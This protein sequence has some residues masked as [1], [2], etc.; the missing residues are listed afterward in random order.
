MFVVLAKVRFSDTCLDRICLKSGIL[1][2][3]NL[4]VCGEGS[5]G[6]LMFARWLDLWALGKMN[7]KG[8]KERQGKIHL[9]K[10]KIVFKFMFHFGML[11]S[12]LRLLDFFFFYKKNLLF[13]FCHWLASEIKGKITK[14]WTFSLSYSHNEKTKKS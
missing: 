7:S 5:F 12:T 9:K 14:S 11:V 8:R 1:D 10:T 13:M 4:H 3:K 2:K 6:V